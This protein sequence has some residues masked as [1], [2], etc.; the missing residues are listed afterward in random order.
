MADGPENTLSSRERFIAAAR[1]LFLQHGYD[2]ASTALIAREAGSAETQM[3]RLFGGK[4]GLLEAV[5]NESWAPLN[6]KLE[7]IASGA[8]SGR[9][10]IL[11]VLS[12][13]IAAFDADP[14]LAFLVLL[15]ERRVRGDGKVVSISRGLSDFSGLVDLLIRR[16]QR[17]GSLAPSLDPAALRSAFMGAAEAMIRDRAI[18][19]REGRAES[20]SRSS[21]RSVFE[22]L[23]G[24][25]SPDS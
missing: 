24:G 13:M 2:G 6:A 15:E 12:A 5:F 3:V 25:I 11:K 4:A 8:R 23:L 21:I 16:G 9:D 17:D 7:A 1:E 19:R 20:F 14:N 18:A 22:F 10:G